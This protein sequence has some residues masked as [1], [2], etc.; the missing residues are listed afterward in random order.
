MA[1][2]LDLSE[3]GMSRLHAEAE[4]RR[5]SVEAVVEEWV[6]SLPAKEEPAKEEIVE[7]QRLSFI[8]MG[9]SASGRRASDADEL[10]AEGFGR[11]GSH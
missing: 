3:D 1:V 8:A 2:T 11:D 10:L 6:T 5:T 7:R 9:S 4:R